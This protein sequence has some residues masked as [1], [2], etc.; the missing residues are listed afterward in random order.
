MTE[1]NTVP[2]LE[3]KSLD[4]N[5]IFAPRQCLERSRQFTKRTEHKTDNT[6]LMKEKRSQTPDGPGK[7]LQSKKASQIE[8]ETE[9][10]KNKRFN[11][12]MHRTPFTKTQHIPQSKRLLLGETIRRRN[13][14]RTLENTNRK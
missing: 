2:I 9:H 6:P 13:I 12:V 11:Q 5:P 10:H 7:K 14:A 8:N 1:K 3:T 4:E